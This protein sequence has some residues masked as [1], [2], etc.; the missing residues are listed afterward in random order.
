MNPAQFLKRKLGA[1]V[2]LGVVGYSLVYALAFV[3]LYNE[4]HPYRVASQWIFENVPAGSRIVSPHWDDKVPVGIPGKDPAIYKMHGRD[5]ELPV[6]ERDT[7]QMIEMIVRRAASADYITFATPRAVDSI[8]RIP[9]EYPNMTAFLRLLWGEKLGFSLVYTTKNRPSFLGITFNDDL[10]DESFSV[11]DHPKVVVFK[12]ELRLSEGEIL[13]RVGAVERYEP[14]PTMND[15]LLMD[16]GGWMPQRQLWDPAWSAMLWL[17]GVVVVLAGAVWILFGRP[18]QC[19]PDGGLGVSL[20]AGILVAFAGSWVGS[21][22]H[23]LP[24]TRAGGRFVVL[25]LISIAL[26]K[27]MVRKSTQQRIAHTA[28]R[29]GIAAVVSALIGALVVLIMR[30]SDSAL[31]GLGESVDTVIFS[32]LMR[33]QESFPW[34]LFVPGRHLSP[35]FL[36]RFVLAWLLKTAG[37]PI[38]LAVDSSM[39]VM[40][41]V[42]GG[43]LY[44]VFSVLL[45]RIR[46][47]VV[48]VCIASIPAVYLL[49]VVRDITTVP[50]IRNLEYQEREYKE[51]A[52]WVA[53]EIEATPF[54]VESCASGEPLSVAPHV[55]LPRPALLAEDETRGSQLCQVEDPEEAY[56]VM[57][58]QGLELFATE[59]AQSA[60]MAV[61]LKRYERFMERPDLFAKVYDDNR[62]AIFVP[63]FSRY[64]PRKTVS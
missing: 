21:A 31:S 6:Y 30:S 47:A 38:E 39:V 50:F 10:A 55:G 35:S 17:V 36:D 53:E 43:L 14:L 20:L 13:E 22:G 59:S 11:Y 40:G 12:N 27:C 1:V 62:I 29:H 7:P 58:R 15:M 28:G 24:L 60:D 5:F 54:I 45:R 64:Y 33:S 61:G 51:L 44:T 46:P 37:T 56:S 57:M 9:E 49:H 25:V 3:Q 41:A 34:D 4:E 26:L 8:P 23:V 19:L 48:G 2:A 32:Y 16:R 52:K 18:F 42:C 63:A